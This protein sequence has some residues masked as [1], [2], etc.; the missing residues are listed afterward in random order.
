M[1]YY[2][3]ININ[4]DKTITGDIEKNDDID[5]V[6]NSLTNILGTLQGGRRMLPE[7]ATNVYSLLFDP[8]DEITA[9]NIGNIMLESI[10]KW[11]ERVV[12]KE[13]AV[14]PDYDNNQYNVSLNFTIENSSK[15]QELTYILKH[16]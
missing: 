5:A 10:Q 12:V 16:L 1:S 14:I 8:I 7:F 13:I 4:L 15:E 11:D 2:S 6:K 3:D 9:Y